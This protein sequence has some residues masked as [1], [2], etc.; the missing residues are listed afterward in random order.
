MAVR[1]GD[2]SQDRRVRVQGEPVDSYPQLAP[3]V[4]RGAVHRITVV[5]E[6]ILNRRCREVTEFG[7][8][9]LSQLID[10]MFA[11]NQVANGAGLAANQI[12]VDLQLFVWDIVDDWGVRHVGHIANPVLDEIA[13]EDRVLVEESEGCLSVPGPYRM[14]PRLDRA[15]VRGRDK[16]GNPLVIE[17]RGYFARCLQHETDHL[18][19]HLYLDRLSKRERKSALREMEGSK[20]ETFARRA[21]AAKK[22]GK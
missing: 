20:E 17:G 5:G 4:E 22:L 6:E 8:P 13:T 21:A 11:T 7:T 3:E 12:D 19:G 2:I 9:E 1:N 10:D 18:H 15:V 16:D 14:V